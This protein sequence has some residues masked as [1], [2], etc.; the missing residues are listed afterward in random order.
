MTIPEKFAS[1]TKCIDCIRAYPDE[2]DP[3]LLLCKGSPQIRVCPEIGRCDSGFWYFR[4]WWDYDMAPVIKLL[5]QERFSEECL[6]H[7]SRRW[8]KYE[9]VSREEWPKVEGS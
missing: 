3:C 8:Y 5:N 1:L 2:K 9:V 7:P 4:I 6:E